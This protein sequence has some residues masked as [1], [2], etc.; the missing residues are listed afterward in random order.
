M[1]TSP[2]SRWSNRDESSY[3][4][5]NS[6]SKAKIKSRSN[7]WSAPKAD[8]SAPMLLVGQLTSMVTLSMLYA[9]TVSPDS[10]SLD[11]PSVWD[12]GESAL[13]VTIIFGLLSFLFLLRVSISGK[14]PKSR[15]RIARIWLLASI[16]ATQLT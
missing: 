15:R 1:G 6:R 10:Q 8:S 5:S 9:G 2:R 16:L 14:A 7:D 12:L 11:G 3:K 13:L 4:E